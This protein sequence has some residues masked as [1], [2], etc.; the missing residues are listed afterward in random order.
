MTQ[1]AVFPVAAAFGLDNRCRASKRGLESFMSLI[2]TM[3]REPLCPG[4]P[5]H[6]PEVIHVA[7]VYDCA[8]GRHRGYGPR[9][10][11]VVI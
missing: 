11:R 1:D 6:E 10:I 8:A 4:S 9:Y 7:A 2:T 3:V 5:L